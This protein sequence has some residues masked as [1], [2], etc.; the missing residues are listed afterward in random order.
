MALWISAR[1]TLAFPA[2]AGRGT[3]IPFRSKEEG[4]RV[5]T[6]QS[7]APQFSI[8]IMEEH[9]LRRHL[10]QVEETLRSDQGKDFQIER[11]S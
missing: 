3:C 10:G 11:S 5:T 9:G 6:G 8:R 2:T 1:W 7:G 4:A